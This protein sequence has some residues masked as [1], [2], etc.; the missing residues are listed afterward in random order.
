MCPLMSDILRMSTEHGF[1]Y[2]A[3]CRELGSVSVVRH[4]SMAHAI[5]CR[6]NR[7]NLPGGSEPVPLA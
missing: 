7:Q 4:P 5:L 6:I 1:D 2:I 3:S